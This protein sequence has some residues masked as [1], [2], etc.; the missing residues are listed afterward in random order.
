MDRKSTSSIHLLRGRHLLRSVVS[1]QAVQ[2]LSSGEAE[3]TATVK[4]GSM[5]LGARSMYRDFGEVV[6]VI[7]ISTDSNASK[8]ILSRRG[9]GKVRHLDTAMLWIQHDVQ[10]QTFTL[11]KV[12]G[13]ENSADLGTKDLAEREMRS[14]LARIDAE[15]SAGRHPLA[16]TAQSIG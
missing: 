14:C 12:K 13:T 1:T 16:L 15:E 6:K 7:E 10:D 9:L 11:K 8:G 2:A 5:A 4:A 3:F